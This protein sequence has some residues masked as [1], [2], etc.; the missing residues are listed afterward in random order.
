MIRVG[1]EAVDAGVAGCL[2]NVG[3]DLRAVG[4]APTAAGW[5]VT[6]PDPFHAD[7]GAAPCDPAER[8]RSV[9]TLRLLE[10][11]HRPPPAPL[12]E[13]PIGRPELHQPRP[14]ALQLPTIRGVRD[15]FEDVAADLDARSRVGAEVEHPRIGPLEARV[16]VADDEPLSS[17][18]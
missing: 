7:E 2:V 1:G 3:D 5:V 17:W 13:A 8:R 18:T 10:D 12:R 11:E 6:V 15:H 16:D 14:E 4:Q 9:R